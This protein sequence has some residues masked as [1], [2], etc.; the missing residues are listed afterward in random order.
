MTKRMMFIAPYSVIEPL[1]LLHLGGLARDLGWERKYFLLKGNDSEEL[2]EK[3]VIFNPDFIGFSFYTGNH[4]QI[5]ELAKLVKEKF[6]NIKLIA[7]GPNPT[8]FPRETEKHFNYVVISEGFRS[9]RNILNDEVEEGILRKT[10]SEPFPHPDREGLYKDYPSY[11]KNPIKSIIAMTGC[12][13]RCPYCYNSSN[14]EDLAGGD[15]ELLKLLS[16]KLGEDR[17]LFPHNLRT[18]EDVVRE[19][20]EIVEKWGE[21]TKM[22]YFQDDHFPPNIGWMKKFIILWKEKVGLPFHSQMRWENASP[23]NLDLLKEAG[24]FGL[25]LANEAAEF[26]VRSE[27]LQRHTLPEVIEKGTEEIMKRRLRL[28]TEQM[29]GLPY[30]GTKTPTLINLEADL[31]LLELN[32][33]LVEKY[34]GPLLTWA[35]VYAPYLGSKLGNY[36]KEIGFYSGNNDDLSSTFFDISRMKF[37]KRWIGEKLPEVKDNS[38]IWLRKVENKRYAEQMAELRNH[39]NFFAHVPKGHILAKKYLTS[40]EPFSHERLG[41]ETIKHLESLKEN[42]ERA[43][44]KLEKVE[45]V[46]AHIGIHN[47]SG[48]KELSLFNLVP[49]FAVLPEPEKAVNKVIEYTKETDGIPVGILSTAT[50]HHLFDLMYDTTTIT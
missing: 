48:E 11:A 29:L 46:K 21:H 38:E 12:P 39:F 37:L 22:I 7:G 42:D 3:I 25:T 33:N 8:Y 4:L 14:A 23:E 30:G 47:L 1:G 10:A 34:G 20:M 49:F 19:G 44:K 6:P 43:K 50:R 36:S 31:A 41:K 24:C 18:P 9:L 17:R 15:E 32:V 45:D 13:F 26:A 35:S 27:L 28:R 16:E 5:F 40:P 2:I